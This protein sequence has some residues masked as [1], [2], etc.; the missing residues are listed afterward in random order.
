MVLEGPVGGGNLDELPDL[1]TELVRLQVEVLVAGG[2]PAI[3]AAQ[4]ATRTIPIVMAGTADPVAQGFIASLAHPG[5]HHGREYSERGTP[6][7]RLRIA[8]GDGTPARAHRCVD[9]SGCANM[10]AQDA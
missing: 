7:K 2:A 3:R 5:E 10:D 8:Q 4:H 9:E 1:A 6:G